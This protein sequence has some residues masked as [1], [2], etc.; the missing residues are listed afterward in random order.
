MGGPGSGRK[1]GSGNKSK[2][3]SAKTGKSLGHAKKKFVPYKTTVNLRT[4]AEKTYYRK[5]V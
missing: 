1:K 5:N 2:A 4:G 3:F